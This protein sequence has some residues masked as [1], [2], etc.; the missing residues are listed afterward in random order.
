MRLVWRKKGQALTTILILATALMVIGSEIAT[1]VVQTRKTNERYNT[2]DDLELLAE[3]GAE[4]AK[5]YLINKINTLK[6]IGITNLN[7]ITKSD[8]EMP[9]SYLTEVID[10]SDDFSLIVTIE[11]AIDFS[12]TRGKFNII[13]KATWVE[14]DI[15]KEAKEIVSVI[16]DNN[17]IVDDIINDVIT[18]RGGFLTQMLYNVSHMSAVSNKNGSWSD[19]NNTFKIALDQAQIVSAKVSGV[20]GELIKNYER[21]TGNKNKGD[22]KNTT[23]NTVFTSYYGPVDY[24]KEAKKVW[25]YFKAPETGWYRFKFWSDDGIALVLNN[26]VLINDFRPKGN[27]PANFSNKNVYLEKDKFYP[28]YIEYFNWGG[29]GDFVMEYNINKRNEDLTKGEYSYGKIA[30]ELFYP[31]RTATPPTY[32]FN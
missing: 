5:N 26:E 9:N 31:S 20:R 23:T 1:S 21:Y 4:V 12:E 3:S 14:K 28:I 27:N 24:Y 16:L 11:K 8:Y 17:S 19:R 32:N 15:T 10:K 25:G 13:S 2:V 22:V 6:S 7:S 30:A 18:S 29:Y